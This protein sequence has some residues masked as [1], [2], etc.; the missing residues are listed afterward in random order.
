MASSSER[1]SCPVCRLHTVERL[2]F[3]VTSTSSEE[4]Q[5]GLNSRTLEYDSVLDRGRVPDIV[6]VC[7]A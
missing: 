5:A 4:L 2:T 1:T 7:L 6:A 3:I